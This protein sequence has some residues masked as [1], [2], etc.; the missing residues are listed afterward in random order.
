MWDFARRHKKKLM[1]VGVLAGAGY[2]AYR[3]Y[4]APIVE[5]PMM[6]QVMKQMTSPDPRASQDA[7]AERE[8]QLEEYEARTSANATQSTTGA[9]AALQEQLIDAVGMKAL[10]PFRAKVD[11]CKHKEEKL[12]LWDKL[13]ELAFT[14]AV[15]A[16]YVVTFQDALRRVQMYIVEA[17]RVRAQLA[18]SSGG[19]DD[20]AALMGALMGGSANPA[21]AA[22]EAYEDVLMKQG[23]EFFSM[24]ATAGGHFCKHGLKKLVSHVGAAV[25]DEFAELELVLLAP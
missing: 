15:A 10:D 13:K 18:Q 23:A 14:Q 22:P 11:A 3:T 17:H 6:R 2:Y 19:E 1:T 12:K 9:L 8:K 7:A 20:M 24:S 16:M 21:P 5:D 4:L 25:A